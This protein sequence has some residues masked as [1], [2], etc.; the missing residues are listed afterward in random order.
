MFEAFISI[1]GSC[2]CIFRF[3][4]LFCTSLLCH[5]GCVSFPFLSLT[6][7]EILSGLRP[8]AAV[9]CFWRNRSN[10]SVPF[11]R[12][13]PCPRMQLRF[14]SS[15]PTTNKR[16]HL[17]T[18]GHTVVSPR[19]GIIKTQMR[20]RGTTRHTSKACKRSQMPFVLRLNLRTLYRHLFVITVVSS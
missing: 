18:G 14:L 20:W 8:P 4:T 9:S 17:G 5:S 6:C 16:G 1:H 15:T 13:R 2:T 19:T 10:V 3:C 7:V 12:S 11:D